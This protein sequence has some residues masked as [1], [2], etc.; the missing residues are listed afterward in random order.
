MQFL[1]NDFDIIS[2]SAIINKYF[3]N[4]APWAKFKNGE[5]EQTEEILYI[6]C[7][8]LRIIAI[9]ISP[10]IPNCANKILDI[11]NIEKNK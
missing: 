7:N 8:F 10:F 11:L 2:L 9:L 5:I 6:T 4:N 3:D 1:R